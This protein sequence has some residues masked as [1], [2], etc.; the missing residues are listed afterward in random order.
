MNKNVWCLFDRGTKI[1]WQNLTKIH[2]RKKRHVFT[3]KNSIFFYRRNNHI[4]WIKHN[5]RKCTNIEYQGKNNQNRLFCLLPICKY[6]RQS[7]SYFWQKGF[8]C[9]EI[10]SQQKY[11]I[12]CLNK[13]KTFRWKKLKVIWENYFSSKHSNLCLVHCLKRLRFPTHFF[14]GF[15]FNTDVKIRTRM[16]SFFY[17][18]ILWIFSLKIKVFLQHFLPQWSLPFVWRRSKLRLIIK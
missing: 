5:K 15:F 9:K 12:C 2:M 11:S 6:L 17:W 7:F 13:C 3:R 10:K 4:S 16:T 14:V 18:Q 8:Y 1:L